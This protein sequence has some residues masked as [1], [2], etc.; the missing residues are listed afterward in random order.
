MNRFPS[1][2][3]GAVLWF[4]IVGLV[5]ADQYTLQWEKP[6]TREDGSAL[7]PSE[8]L[9]YGVSIDGTDLYFTREEGITINL[10]WTIYAE[11]THSLT[12]VTID[13][14]LLL[15]VPSSAVVIQRDPPNP[16]VIV[17]P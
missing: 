13:E 4:G 6:T 5:L 14:N 17:C 9:G 7:A 3:L 16:P 8:I 15:S 10:A 1:C 11:G 2:I 12:V